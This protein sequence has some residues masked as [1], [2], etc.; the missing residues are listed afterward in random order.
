[1]LT[2]SIICLILASCS[3][4]SRPTTEEATSALKS[5]MDKLNYISKGETKDLT[6]SYIEWGATFTADNIAPGVVT[7]FAGVQPP[8]TGS[9]V[10]PAEVEFEAYAIAVNNYRTDYN[11]KLLVYY[12][13]N[14]MDT[15]VA[16]P[17][18]QM[19]R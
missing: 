4:P 2:A 10:Y 5:V 3:S 1:M 8:T 16:Y 7:M 13:R 19:T 9:T 18:E 15:L 17:A 14:A 11:G 12:W 6:I